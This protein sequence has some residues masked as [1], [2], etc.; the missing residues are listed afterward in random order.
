MQNNNEITKTLS[1]HHVSLSYSEGQIINRMQ[2][3]IPAKKLTVILG[4]NGCGKSSLLKMLSRIK[5]PDEGCILLGED[6]ILK[7]NSKTLARELALLVQKPELP[8]GIEV[9][10]LVSRGRYPHQKIWQQ[11]SLDDETAVQEALIAT[12]LTE[13]IHR[14]VASLSGGQ[15]QQ[16]WLAMV[17]AQKSNILMLDEPTS[18]LDI[19]AQLL[20]MN[21]CLSLRDQGKTLVMV[22]HD[23]NQAFRY[24]DNIIM[25]HEGKIVAEGKPEDLA[26]PDIIHTVY[27]VNT[28][29]ITDPE[30]QTPMIIPK[31]DPSI[32]PLYSFS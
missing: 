32:E 19:R 6:N 17:L 30:S 2:L 25:M 29:I 11:W 23:I 15:Q 31:K 22:L 18:F 24:A 7:M 10:E 20:V 4:P 1:A 26:N 12:G 3:A 21:F 28:T 16:V 13:L 8:E 5:H 9:I 27:G 14:P